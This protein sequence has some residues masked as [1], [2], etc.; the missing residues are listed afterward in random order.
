MIYSTN[1]QRGNAGLSLAIAYYGCNDYTV[2]I[3]LN[4]TQDYDLIVDKNGDLLKVQVK[5]VSYKDKYGAY[6]A[7]LKS[8]GGTKGAI[9]KTVKDTNIDIVFIV[10]SDKTLYE[11]PISEIE[12]S[13]SLN[14][15]KEPSRY[16][17]AKDYS[18][19]IVTI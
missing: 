18:K 5:F 15:R 4:D 16:S 7:N 6:Q 1:K 14:L 9:Y 13:S 17:N 10:C 8:S 3:P 11:I 12:N 2:S 19:F